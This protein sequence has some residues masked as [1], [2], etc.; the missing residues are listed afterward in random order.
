MKTRNIVFTPKPVFVEE[1]KR[2]DHDQK[3][4]DAGKRYRK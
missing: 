3:K 4:Q 1:R 2:P